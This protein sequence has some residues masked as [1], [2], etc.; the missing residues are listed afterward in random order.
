ME[1]FRKLLQWLR[2]MEISFLS[3]L[4]FQR[5][6]LWSK[7]GHEKVKK[8]KLTKRLI[9][10]LEHGEYKSFNQSSLRWLNRTRTRVWNLSWKRFLD[11]RLIRV[12]GKKAKNWRETQCVVSN[13]IDPRHLAPDQ[14]EIE[15]GKSGYVRSPTL[16]ILETRAS[17]E[18]RESVGIEIANLGETLKWF[19][20]ASRDEI[21]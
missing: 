8:K 6:K 20:S 18:E 3:P 2:S 13:P 5:Y 17:F 19:R 4:L 10:F 15:R 21:W 11:K 1:K 14:F 7:G 16:C 9:R 12:G